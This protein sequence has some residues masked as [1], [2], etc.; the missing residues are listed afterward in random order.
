VRI[1]AMTAKWRNLLAMLLVFAISPLSMCASTVCSI[2]CSFLGATVRGARL[3]GPERKV[4]VRGSVKH[5]A[6]MHCHGPADAE[7]RRS[8]ALG[9]RRGPCHGEKCV[10]PEGVVGPTLAE[11]KCTGPTPSVRIEP[12][13]GISQWTPP[14]VVPHRIPRNFLTG[15]PGLFAVS[16]TLR[17]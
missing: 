13:A 7:G 14:S 15:S 5:D 17:I 6:G 1:M 8:V 11:R 16:G 12:S 10:P 3:T 4:A 2:T 9:N